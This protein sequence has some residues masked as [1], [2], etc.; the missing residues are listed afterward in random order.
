MTD[1]Y[2]S[3]LLRLILDI[4]CGEIPSDDLGDIR[5][6]KSKKYNSEKSNFA[7]KFQS[8]KVKNSSS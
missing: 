3:H 8:I 1:A 2:A 6:K 7:S 4:L 5:S